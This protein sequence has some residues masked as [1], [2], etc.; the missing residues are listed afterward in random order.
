MPHQGQ[1][2]TL[3][4]PHDGSYSLSFYNT[5][6]IGRTI[7]IQVRAGQTSIT[8]PTIP[9]LYWLQLTS[10]EGQRIPGSGHLLIR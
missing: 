3:Q 7:S 4:A 6:G 2:L 10:P 5:A 1:L 9:G 8:P